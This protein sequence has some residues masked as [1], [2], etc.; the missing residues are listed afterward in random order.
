MTLWTFDEVGHG[1][2]ATRELRDLM[3]ASVFTSPKP[4]RYMTRLLQIGSNK[5]SLV[6]DFFSG[7]SSTAHTIIKMNAEDSGN[8]KFIM[9]QLPEPTDEKDQRLQQG[10]AK[11]AESYYP[12]FP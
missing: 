3:G 12:T 5:D 1:Q 8:R 2:E 9:V 7:S 4:I 6:L 10:H 11:G